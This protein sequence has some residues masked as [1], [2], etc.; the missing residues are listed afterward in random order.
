MKNSAVLFVLIMA[1]C[2]RGE[3]QTNFNDSLSRSRNTLTEHYMVTLGAFALVNIG[4]GFLVASQTQGEA[5]YAW[6]M[7]AYWNFINLGIAGLGYLGARKALSKTYSLAE[8]EKAQLSVEKTYVLNFGLDLF[9]IAGGFYL[10]ERGESETNL[11]SKQQYKGYGASIAI[12]GGC[13]AIMD[14]IM[15]TLHHHN[16]IRVNNKLK[17]LELHAGPGAV[18]LTWNL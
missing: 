12:Q 9:Y 15:T 11:L 7:N 14:A 18:A 13:L 10:R 2:A 3:A 5:K 4:S 1:L 16:S 17:A 6:R 8:N